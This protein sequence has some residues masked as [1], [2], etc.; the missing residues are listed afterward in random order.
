MS[1]TERRTGRPNLPAD[2]RRSAKIEV[3][4]RPS[5]K[6]RL[7]DIADRYRIK[8]SEAARQALAIG[9]AEMEKKK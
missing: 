2:V 8:E 4:V 6:A 1:D 7:L 9:M 3:R 5:A